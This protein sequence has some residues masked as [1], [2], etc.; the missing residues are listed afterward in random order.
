MIETYLTLTQ[1]RGQKVSI[2][3]LFHKYQC[4]AFMNISV[5]ENFKKFVSLIE[6]VHLK[7]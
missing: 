6:L 3:L 5:F 7:E 4:L 1:E 2:L